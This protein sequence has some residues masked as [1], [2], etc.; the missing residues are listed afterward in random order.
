MKLLIASD[1]RG[2]LLKE[3]IKNF[4][5]EENITFS[6][7]GTFSADSVDYVD[8]AAPVARAVGNGDFDLGI[9]ICWTGI[10]MCI[11]ANKFKNVRA[12]VGHDP[13]TAKLSK[14]HNNTNIICFGSG[15]IDSDFALSVLKDWLNTKFTSGRHELR[16]EKL[17]RLEEEIYKNE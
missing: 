2:I 16:L 3:R 5:I 6:D 11:V 10:G 14:E 15:F 17:H 1:H 7:L 4:L 12:F 9:L 13:K 8:F